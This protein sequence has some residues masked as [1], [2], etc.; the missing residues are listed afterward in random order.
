MSFIGGPCTQGPGM[1]ADEELKFPIRSHHDIDK[2]NAKFMKK[3]IKHYEALA[4][5]AAANGHII[6]IYSADVN[7]TGLHEMKYCSNYTGGHMILADSFNTSLF[8]QSFQRVFLKDQNGCFRMGFGSTLELKTSRELKVS[9]AI[10][11]CVSLGNKSQYVSESETGVGG[12][13]SWKISGVYPNTTVA[14]Y[15]DVVNQQASPLPQGG[16]GY[17]QFVNTYQHSSGTKRIRVT[18]IA[19]K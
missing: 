2:D 16:R 10:G 4:N 5:R 17:V 14:F 9:G 7:Q 1:I 18:T 3:A 15:F 11:A 12:T 8:K 19:R 6:D 13:S